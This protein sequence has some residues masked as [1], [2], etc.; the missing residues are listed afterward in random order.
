MKKHDLIITNYSV[1]A[2]RAVLGAVMVYKN[3]IDNIFNLVI[4]I[5]YFYIP[6]HQ[7]IFS[8]MKELRDKDRLIDVIGIANIAKTKNI[9]DDI[10]YSYLLE[11]IDCVPPS[12]ELIKEHL[13]ILQ[14]KFK[15]RSLLSSCHELILKLHETTGTDS[16]VELSNDFQTTIL[17]LNSNANKKI[18]HISESTKELRDKYR[19]I[20]KGN[21][22]V[23]KNRYVTTGISSINDKIT[24]Y[25]RGALII[26]GARP[27]MGKSSYA[28]TGAVSIA[29]ED[30]LPVLIISLEMKAD[31]LTQRLISHES[32]ENSYKIKS[33]LA[34]WD[35]VD[36]H[37]DLIEELPIYIQDIPVHKISEIKTHAL[38][39]I[40]KHKKLGAIF[41]DYLQLIDGED[42]D[43]VKNISKISRSLKLLAQE[44]DVPVIALSQLNRALE[45]RANKRPLLSDLRQSG[46]IE[47][48]ADIVKFLYR[49][50]YYNPDTPKKRIAEVIIAK[51]REGEVGTVE[52][53]FD[54]TI[55][56]FSAIEKEY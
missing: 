28:L 17:N 23:F 13:E 8:I 36:K 49:D 37:M 5:E 33:G 7:L 30:K 52:L 46:S 55:T 53:Y 50:E 34:D 14:D 9:L 45:Q 2:E 47:Q 6:T 1:E 40:Q 22:S 56:R 31:Q 29:K 41:V 27:A 54:S 10:G 48:D 11:L 4:D 19:E 25:Q 42:I 38:Q 32:G 26:V 12:S 44:L 35:N 39:I 21:V 24:G 16:F 15:R 20:K 3:Q 18:T 43:E 51:H